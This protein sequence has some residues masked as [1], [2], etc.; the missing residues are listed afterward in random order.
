MESKRAVG[1][2]N[3][4]LN[5]AMPQGERHVLAGSVSM[6]TYPMQQLAALRRNGGQQS[7]GLRLKVSTSLAITKCCEVSLHFQGW[8]QLETDHERCNMPWLFYELLLLCGLKVFLLTEVIA[9][10]C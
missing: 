7:Y 3:G 2:D 5:R 6:V 4:V 8:A 9:I 1:T 10:P